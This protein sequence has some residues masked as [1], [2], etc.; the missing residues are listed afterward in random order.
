MPE[1]TDESPSVGR[2]CSTESGNGK[3]PDTRW[4]LIVSARAENSMI[5]SR[6]LQELC[7][8]YWMPVYCYIR[9][10][11]SSPEDAEDLTQG[12][13]MILQQQDFPL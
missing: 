2:E 9:R 4:S 3:F 8:L 12:F 13:F 6:A 10:R 11:G 5:V 1:E 7:Q